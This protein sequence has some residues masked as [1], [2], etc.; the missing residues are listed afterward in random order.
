MKTLPAA[1]LVS[2][3]L[4]SL[5]ANAVA[6]SAES[7]K[8]PSLAALEKQI[9]DR[10]PETRVTDVDHERITTRR[11]DIVGEDGVI[12]MSLSANTPPPII[13]GIQYQRRF[14]VAGLVLY[15]AHGSERG[16]IGVADAPGGS[17]PVLAL[18]HP[19]TD[20]IGWRVDTDGAVNFLINQAPP[21][22]REPKLGNRLVPGVQSP[23]RIKLS[24]AADGTPAVALADADDH[25]RVRMTVTTEGY[26]AIEFL[27]ASGKVVHTLAP[28]RDQRH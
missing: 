3:L 5:F 14:N 28:E 26:G 9:V 4:P 20:A 1:M 23:T 11:I 10:A 19:A 22:V 12:R 7:A 21:L 15:D 25:P 8:R 2:G 16:G 17:T 13:D 24:V 18:D 27:D 6:Q